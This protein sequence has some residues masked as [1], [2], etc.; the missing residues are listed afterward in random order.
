MNTQTHSKSLVLLTEQRRG[1]RNAKTISAFSA[2]TRKRKSLLAVSIGTWIL[3]ALLS[4][5][6]YVSLRNDLAGIDWLAVLLLGMVVLD[7]II[8]AYYFHVTA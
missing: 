8:T 2:R 3:T 4:I 1:D 7:W 5:V 6:F